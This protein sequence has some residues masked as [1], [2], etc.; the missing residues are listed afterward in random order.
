MP[1]PIFHYIDGGADDEVTLARNTAAFE[2]VDL[3][4]NVLA[5]VDAV[6]L[7]TEVLGCELKNAALVLANGN[8]ALVSSRG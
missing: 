1:A 3:V 6:D 4:P 2:A 8:A 5:G 7:R